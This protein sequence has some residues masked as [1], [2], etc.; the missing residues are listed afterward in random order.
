MNRLELADSIASK[1]KLTADDAQEIS[2]KI[3]EGIA[4]KHGLE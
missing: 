1:S 3:K 4:E 2:E